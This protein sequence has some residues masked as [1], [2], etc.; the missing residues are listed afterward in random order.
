MIFSSRSVTLA[1]I[2][3]LLVSAGGFLLVRLGLRPLRDETG[4]DLT[5]L[6]APL[7][8]N[9]QPSLVEAMDDDFNTSAAVAVLFELVRVINQARDDGATQAQLQPTQATRTPESAS[10][11]AV[12]Y[13][14]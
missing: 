1:I 8:E 6:G 13:C 11:A 4:L 5:G 9:R 10:P 14:D 7:N 3:A 12:S 2:L